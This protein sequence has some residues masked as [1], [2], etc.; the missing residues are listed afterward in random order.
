M[1][2]AHDIL[3]ES[4]GAG[5]FRNVC[6]KELLGAHVEALKYLCE[7]FILQLQEP[8]LGGQLSTLEHAYVKGFQKITFVVVSFVGSP[9]ADYHL[10]CHMR[11]SIIPSPT[12]GR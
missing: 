7:S 2:A 12:E 9:A 8:L 6:V 5:L 10:F 3:H 4:I 11:A 1:S